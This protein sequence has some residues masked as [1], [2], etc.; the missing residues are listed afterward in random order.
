MR[1]HHFFLLTHGA[2]ALAIVLMASVAFQNGSTESIIVSSTLSLVTLGAAA[3]YASTRMCNGLSNLEAVVADQDVCETLSSGLIEVDEAATRIAVDAGR[4]ESVAASN[5]EQTRDFQSMMFLL[6]RRGPDRPATSGQLRGLLAGLGNRLHNYLADVQIAAADIES[7]SQTI[8]VGA[9]AQSD[10]A[11]M[12]T[13]HLEQLSTAIELVLANAV[14]TDSAN[15]ISMDLAAEVQNG[16]SNINEGLKQ[17][18]GNSQSCESKLRGLSDPVQQIN[19]IVDTISDIAARTDL[20]ALNASIEAVRVGENGKQFAKV[21]DEVRKLAEQST[22]ATREITSLLESMRL[23]TQESMHRFTS[24]RE[25]VELQVATATEAVASLSRMCQSVDD[26][27]SRVRKIKESSNAQLQLVQNIANAVE[28]IA[29]I[30]KASRND[31]EN[32]TWRSKS[33]LQMPDDFLNAVKRLRQCDGAV[34][35]ETSSLDPAGNEG[36][37]QP[38]TA[39]NDDRSYA[40]ETAPRQ[41]T[42]IATV[43]ILASSLATAE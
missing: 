10:T 14:E 27:T 33:L 8:I 22:D 23:V 26:S 39:I 30:A 7:N 20:L 42:S 2:A 32:A 34:A 12:T 13:A 25:C 40:I 29:D 28:K 17:I 18:R 43:P 36:A 6:N 19:S 31:A 37:Q 3:W 41:T 35:K 4:W 1:L 5:R 24:G 21:A 9:D 16:L 11:I 15:A 38:Q